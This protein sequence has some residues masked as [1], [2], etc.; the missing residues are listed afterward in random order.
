[1]LHRKTK[2]ETLSHF[3]SF[4]FHSDISSE[5]LNIEDSTLLGSHFW[6]QSVNERRQPVER[7]KVR[8]SGS[9]VMKG[10]VK[11]V[12]DNSKVKV[13]W[14][15]GESLVKVKAELVCGESLYIFTH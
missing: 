2:L 3:V 7:G 5:F 15:L 4:F 6:L 10:K 12:P 14:G 1:M 9:L 11:L 13:Q 8:P